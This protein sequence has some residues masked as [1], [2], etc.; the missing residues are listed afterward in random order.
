MTREVVQLIKFVL[1]A[2]VDQPVRKRMQLYRGLAEIIGEEKE[3]RALL[4]LAND[5]EQSEAL[6]REFA[7]SFSQKNPE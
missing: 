3:A 4:K 7:F 2:A 6:C 5:L 1:D